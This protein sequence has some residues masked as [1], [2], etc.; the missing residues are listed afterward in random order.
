[1]KPSRTSAV[2]RYI[3]SKID[4]S[5]RPSRS[6][7]ATDIRRVL[8]LVLASDIGQLDQLKKEYVDFCDSEENPS[9]R[10]DFIMENVEGFIALLESEGLSRKYP[11]M[12]QAL[13]S[14]DEAVFDKSPRYNNVLYTI[15]KGTAA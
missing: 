2:L 14:G 10:A 11:G 6:L 15:C 7:V 3:A 13:N 12:F 8:T 4:A 1:M 9:V 5:K